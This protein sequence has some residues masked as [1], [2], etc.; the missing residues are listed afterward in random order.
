MVSS[1]PSHGRKSDEHSSLVLLKRISFRDKSKSRPDFALH[2]DRAEKH[3]F[4]P[5]PH[6]AQIVVV[7]AFVI[8]EF[9]EGLAVSYDA[10]NSILF[11]LVMF[12]QAT[13]NEFVCRHRG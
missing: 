13:N 3:L 9:F 2:F 7:E 12:V 1:S 4:R 5:H 10:M 6:F 11:A 8:N